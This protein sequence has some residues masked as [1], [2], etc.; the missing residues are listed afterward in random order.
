[1][2]FSERLRSL[3]EEKGITQKQ[4]A[5]T[6]HIPV[7]TLGGYVQGTSEP[8]FE[9]LKLIASHFDVTPDY[10]LDFHTNYI[11]N[12]KETDL[13]RIFRSLPP[14]QQ[15][16]YIEQGKAFLKINARESANAQVLPQKAEIEQDR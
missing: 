14:S 4:L 12:S 8:D 5:T 11:K 15:D 7:S 2:I 10:L 16:L 1:M 6:L 9:T 13:L 3:I